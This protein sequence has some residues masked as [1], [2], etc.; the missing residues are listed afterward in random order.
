MPGC[1]C[2]SCIR[3]YCSIVFIAGQMGDTHSVDATQQ[4]HTQVTGG[5]REIVYTDPTPPATNPFVI[6]QSTTFG[7]GQGADTYFLSRPFPHGLAPD[8]SLFVI[9]VMQ[10]EIHRFSPDGTHLS[11]FGNRE[12]G[13]GEFNVLQGLTVDGERLYINDPFSGPREAPR[14]VLV[15]RNIYGFRCSAASQ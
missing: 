15:E 5:V 9:D 2:N 13:P 1:T 4:V 3:F 7:A 12:G 6:E 8:G 14:F 11:V 10:T